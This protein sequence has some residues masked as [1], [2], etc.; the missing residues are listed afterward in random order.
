MNG[1]STA[2]IWYQ[3]FVDPVEQSSYMNRLS[4]RLQS[5]AAPG[6]TIDVYGISPPDRFFHP[7]TEFAVRSRRFARRSKLSAMA[8][9]RSLLAIFR[10]RA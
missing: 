3:S 6:T 1:C 4:A 2:R 5:L 7:M 10:S 9:T 8:T